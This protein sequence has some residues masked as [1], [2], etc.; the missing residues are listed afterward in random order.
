[1]SAWLPVRMTS[2]RVVVVLGLLSGCQ[3]DARPSVAPA[4][5]A[6]S[7][8]RSKSALRMRQVSGRALHAR[9]FREPLSVE[10]PWHAPRETAPLPPGA[11]AGR[12]GA[13]DS[14]VATLVPPVTGARYVRERG[15]RLRAAID[16]LPPERRAYGIEG[17][18][19][20]EVFGPNGDD[21][22]CEKA[23]VDLT[24]SHQGGSY[25]ARYESDIYVWMEPLRPALYSLSSTCTAALTTA[26]SAVAPAVGQGCSREDEAAHFPAGSRCRTCLTADGD[27][28]R[29]IA[30]G[31]CRTQMAR[32]VFVT[33]GGREQSYDVLEATTLACA[34]TVKITTTVL[35][36]E[37][38]DDNTVPRA[39]DHEQ[40]ARW[41]HRF[42]SPRT[43]APELSC[44]SNVT[45][46]PRLARGDV[47][48]G[49]VDWIRR[50]GEARTPLHDRLFLASRVEVEGDVYEDLPL[51]PETVGAVSDAYE[52]DGWGLPPNGLRPD[53]VDPGRVDDT[54]ARDWIAA[55]SMKTAT[56]ITG[57][58][59]YSYNRNLCAPEA[60]RGPDAEGRY[61]CRV[62]GYSG[63]FQPADDDHWRYDWGAYLYDFDPLTVE[64]APVLTLAATGLP[65]PSVPGG[66]V[67]HVL[68]STT[69]ADPEWEGCRW[70]QTFAPDELDNYETPELVV[71]T[72]T[73]QTYRFGKDP[74]LPIRMVVATN[75]HRAFCFEGL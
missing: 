65:D 25:E 11:R 12:A 4:V 50:P 69:L 10:L 32:E 36:R 35:T 47:L 37:L 70:P 14:L 29:C 19:A 57:V 3:V 49:Y 61:H 2:A 75:W 33:E 15:A 8:P 48:L 63:D 54:Y 52:Q 39:Y 9:G 59:L 53:G 18:T 27:H 28:A 23:A 6:S 43:R 68:G 22:L 71:H 46:Q 42:W 13:D 20:A 73:S 55:M 24:L 21:G 16:A 60:W 5:Q 26:G 31:E 38:G 56:N 64:T 67:P 66:H 17:L 34:P 44:T 41:C 51:Y 40:V 72:F 30:A 62:P 74:A 58:P 7:T 1:M 45:G